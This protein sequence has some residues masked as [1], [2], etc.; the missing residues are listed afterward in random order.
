MCA[1]FFERLWKTAGSGLTDA[2]SP[3]LWLLAE[4]THRC[5][6]QCAYCSNPLE[7]QSRRS[8]LDTREWLRVLTEARA[9]G[10]AQLGF[11]G[12]EP[13]LRQDL[14]ALIAEAAKLGYYSNLI[15]SGEG[16]DQARVREFKRLG[17]DHIQL[18]F[19]ADEAGLNDELAG[20]RCFDH[21]I[22]M[23]R[24]VKAAGYPMVLCFVI[25]RRN[26]E[27]MEAMLELAVA[28]EADYVE[29]AN[30]QY[31]G[32]AL[33][34]RSA[35]LPSR[36]Q[37]EAAEAIADR[38]K[39]RMAG[40]MKIYYVVPDYYA[41]RP[42]ACMNGWGNVFLAIAPDGAALPCHAAA[43]LPD[44]VFPNVRDHHLEW[45]WRESPAF[46]EFRG[47]DW[48]RAPCKDCPERER[49]FGGCRCQA[50]RLTGDARNA[51]PVCTKSPQRV[52]ID[53]AIEGRDQR[54]SLHMRA[55][56]NAAA[57]RASLP[58]NGS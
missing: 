31:L 9:L 18:S 40:K 10:A 30:T 32:W 14:E 44:I 12:G 46:N 37:L 51:D 8:E 48:M 7:L 58:P 26:I 25:H 52:L 4:L 28:L 43:D 2:V 35:L 21:K 55:P 19:Q 29:L 1:N 38:Y 36:A 39:R 47:F 6:L 57:A 16:M 50:Y 45:I 11:S 13:C 24:A 53:Q 17:L 5:P 15:T 33:S 54:P 42:K 3:P 20:T 49:D 22:Q 41:S 27:R 34:N 56:K 23:A